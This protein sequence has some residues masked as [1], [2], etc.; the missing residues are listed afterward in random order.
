M[1]SGDEKFA[2]RDAATVNSDASTGS[3]SDRGFFSEP[4]L[5]FSLPLSDFAEAFYIPDDPTVFTLAEVH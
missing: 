5:S 4:P 3:D 1:T 2:C